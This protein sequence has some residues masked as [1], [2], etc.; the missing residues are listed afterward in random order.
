MDIFVEGN[1]KSRIRVPE[2]GQGQALT[3]SVRGYMNYRGHRIRISLD[4]YF[5]FTRRTNYFYI[6]HN[7]NIELD[8]HSLVRYANKLLIVIGESL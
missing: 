7:K 6:I 1:P 8:I 5:R 4:N 3:Y 2:I